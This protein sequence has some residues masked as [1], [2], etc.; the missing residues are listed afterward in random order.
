MGTVL[1]DMADLEYATDLVHRSIEPTPQY[2]WPLLT[3]AMGADVWV[4][5]ENHT[6]VG[7]FKVRGGLV[8]VN[9]LLQKTSRRSPAWCPRRGA[10]TGRASRMRDGR[11]DCP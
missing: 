7:A 1:F 6:I 5:H 4:K 8:Y 2:L 9:R 11:P 10:T 3:E